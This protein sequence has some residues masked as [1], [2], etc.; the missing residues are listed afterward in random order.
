VISR[1]FVLT[2]GFIAFFGCSQQ[3]V[4]FDR[5]AVQ[6]SVT[7]GGK[8]LTAGTIRFVP[9]A[10]V[11]GPKVSLAVQEGQF[12]SDALNGPTL[13]LHRVEIELVESNVYAHDDEQVID[14]LKAEQTSR[15]KNSRL[16]AIYNESSTLTATIESVAKEPLAFV[17]RSRP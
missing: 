2:A 3:Q 8:P 7:L 4:G 16:P 10:G 9:A 17:L 6:G 14:R 11:A 15:I 5:V 12:K 13:G 1:Y